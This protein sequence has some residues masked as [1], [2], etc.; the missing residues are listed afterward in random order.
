MNHQTQPL[1]VGNTNRQG[2]TIRKEVVGSD[3]TVLKRVLERPAGGNPYTAQR[4]INAFN[5]PF[6]GNPGAGCEFKCVY[7][8]LQVPFF[9]RH[10]TLPH[11]R[12]VNAVPDFAQGTEKF[13]KSRAH[14]PQ[15]MKRIQWGVSTEMWL[16]S[17]VGIWNPQKTLEAFRDHGQGW[18]LHMVTK[19]PEILKYKGLLAELKDRVQV[20]VSFVTLDEEASRVFETGTPSVAQ[21]LRIVEELAQ[22]GIFVR[23]MMMPCMRQY[24]LATVKNERHMVFQH[25]SSGE[26]APGYKKV[27]EKDGNAEGEAVGIHLHRK[28]RWRQ[29]DLAESRDWKP[30][31]V[32]DWSK[33]AEAQALWPTTGARAYKQKDLNYYFVDELLSAHAAKRPPLRERGRVEDPTAECLVHS[34][35][36]VRDSSGNPEVVEVEAWHL[37]RKEWHG[38]IPPKILRHK[39]DFGYHLHSPIDWIDCK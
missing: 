31:V 21:R 23:M 11:G 12:E 19:C 9:Q 15:Y 32:R 16:P 7:C 35:E 37:P 10:V 4:K 33:L 27:T 39:M 36:S 30:V 3:G 24:E 22:A 20:E 8:Y 13:L 2:Y 6:T 38:P 34:G 25:Q 1:G 17:T 28:N 18:M 14:L 5:F 26:K 29:L